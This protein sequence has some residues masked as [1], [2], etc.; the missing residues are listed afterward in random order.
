MVCQ[1][2]ERLHGFLLWA[3]S[4]TPRS[5]APMIKGVQSHDMHPWTMAS[6]E[7][8]RSLA[9]PRALAAARSPGIRPSF[10]LPCPFPRCRALPGLPGGST[11]GSL[12]GTDTGWGTSRSAFDA[13][14]RFGWSKRA[15]V[16]LDPRIRVPLPAPPCAPRRSRTWMPA[17]ASASGRASSERSPSSH[18]WPK[19]PGLLRAPPA[20][21]SPS[22]RRSACGSW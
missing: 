17:P 10:P 21:A 15:L 8:T 12:Q 18:G 19:E 2:A 6:C 5:M 14:P 16:K 1:V 11:S 9:R 3:L 13:A 22:P 7:P 20:A 4:T